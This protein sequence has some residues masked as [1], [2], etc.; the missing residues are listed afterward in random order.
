MLSNY[1]AQIENN[2]TV[3]SDNAEKEIELIANELKKREKFAFIKKRIRLE[4]PT[5]ERAV[6]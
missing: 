4:S 2:E 3:V 6:K 5:D 1:C